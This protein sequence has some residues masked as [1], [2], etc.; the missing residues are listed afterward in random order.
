MMNR[1][2]SKEQEA[3]LRRQKRD[4]VFVITVRLLL[5]VMVLAGWEFA[6]DREWINSFIFSSPSKVV[7]CAIQ[8]GWRQL[9]PHIGVT[10]L[11]T[12]GSFVAVSLLSL[13][14]AIGLWWNAKLS[15]I[16]EPYLVVLNSLPKSAM[17]PI[18]IV[19]LGA[20]TNTIMVCAISVA[21]F[22]SILSLYTAFSNV[23]SEKL[24]LIQTLGGSR[25]QMLR[26]VVL[27]ASVP[28]ML[29]LMK[30][31]VGLCLVGVIIGEFLSAK[32]GLGYLIIY[33]SQTFRLDWVMLSIAILC[34]IAM[35]LYGS[36]QFITK[37]IQSEHKFDTI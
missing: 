27:P 31:N 19:W 7:G 29:S 6:A 23:D 35:L 37:F 17:A 8:L 33:G 12:L 25:S 13:L 9:L 1:S 18:L 28:S 26:M 14:M 10:L 36:L 34:G 21:V 2:V 20:N 22:G 32:K 3:F 16:S 24:K 5:A 11:E 15:K 30:V 4:K